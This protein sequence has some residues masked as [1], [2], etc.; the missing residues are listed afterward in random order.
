MTAYRSEAIREVETDLQRARARGMIR[1][2]RYAGRTYTEVKAERKRKAMKV[3]QLVGVIVV[4]L[5]VAAVGIS[6]GCAL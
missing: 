2:P 3:Y 4:I 1:T 5:T 6:R